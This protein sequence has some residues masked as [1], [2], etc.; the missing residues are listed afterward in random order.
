MGEKVLN[1]RPG[2]LDDA[3]RADYARAQRFDTSGGLASLD[4]VLA[5]AELFDVCDGERVVLRY[6]LRVTERA[7]GRQGEIVA[8]VGG[9]PGLRLVDAFLPVI[10]RQL[11]GVRR[12]KVTTARP[13]L[14]KRLLQHGYQ[15]RGFILDKMVA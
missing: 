14:A 4:E 1:L 9:C 15:L 2:A 12:V 10:E 11:A 8:A 6:A 5:G 7:N 3:A 13:K